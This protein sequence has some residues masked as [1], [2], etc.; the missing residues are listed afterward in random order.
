MVRPAPSAHCMQPRRHSISVPPSDVRRESQRNST[1]CSKAQRESELLDIAPHPHPPTTPRVPVP[2]GRLIV[3]L[4][5]RDR[6]SNAVHG[7]CPRPHQ[8]REP[9]RGSRRVTY[10]RLVPAQLP[11]ASASGSRRPSS[12]ASQ[13]RSTSRLQSGRARRDTGRGCSLTGERPGGIRACKSEGECMDSASDHPSVSTRRALGTRQ[14]SLT[15][16]RKR[17]ARP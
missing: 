17:R 4:Q 9:E 6:D 10:P 2:H 14:V 1:K 13:E 11:G 5:R 16:S 3:C 7:S 15:S 12:Q 8:Q